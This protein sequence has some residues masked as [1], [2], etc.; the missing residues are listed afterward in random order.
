[1]SHCIHSWATTGSVHLQRVYV[2]QKKI[3]R[4]ICRVR[5]RT[6]TGPLHKTLNSLN[7]GQ[8]KD[9]C[10][11]LFMHKLTDCMLLFMFEIMLIL[12][13]DEN[14]YCTRLANAPYLICFNDKNVE[15]YK[16]FRNKIVAKSMK[17][18]RHRL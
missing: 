4:I 13:S 15:N 18:H 1:M 10:I 9:H 6:D 16:T 7:V 11:S 3:I 17:F 2:I 8:I 14:N 5:H 12:T